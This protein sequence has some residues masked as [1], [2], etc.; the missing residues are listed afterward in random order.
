MTMF[1]DMILGRK[2]VLVKAN[3]RVLALYKGEVLGIFGPGE[4]ALPNRRGMLELERHDMNRPV[5]ASAYEKPLFNG[6]PEAARRELTVIR[7]TAREVAVVERDGELYTVL[8]PNQKLVVW[9]AAGPWT[10]TRVDL[11]ERL[12]IDP[13]LMRLMTRARRTEL[14]TAF[15]VNDGQV[16]LLFVDGT[17]QRMLQPGMHAFWNVGKTIQV[18]VVDL[19]RQSLDVTGQELLTRDKVTIRVNISAEYR[20]VDPLKAVSEVKDFADALYRALQFAFRQTLGTLTL[21]QIL[22]RKVTVNAEAAEK[23]RADMAAIGVEVSAIELKDVI[24]PGE[25]RDI[26]NQVVAAE[27]QAEANVIRRREETNATRSLL[28]T[29]K[30]MAE[31]PV[32]LRLKE[33]EALEAIA[34]KVERLTIHNG[35]AGLMNDIVQLRDK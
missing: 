7:T 9:N 18:R 8:S 2:R 35:T 23:V 6:L 29:A 34:G 33:L 32:M 25:M 10:E 17:H 19:K 14:T 22:E 21:D 27:K 31:N 30:V 5:F 1:L 24:L 11:T 16:G 28:N 15:L 26:L 4:H 3:E 13:E 20:V 12:D